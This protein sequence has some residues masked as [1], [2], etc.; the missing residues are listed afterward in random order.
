MNKKWIISI[1]SFIVVLLFSL[2]IYRST[3]KEIKIL[4]YEDIKEELNND[5][6]S[7]VYFGK[8]N[9]NISTLLN[10]F[11]KNNEFEIYYSSAN[12]D[13]LNELLK[14]NNLKTDNLEVFVLFMEGIPYKVL[15]NDLD[16]NEYTEQIS[17]YFYGT[18]PEDE[19]VYKTPNNAEQL[20]KKINS[21]NYTVMI[22]GQESCHYCDLYKNVFNE[23]ADL[24]KLDIYYI[25]VDTFSADEYKKIQD[26]NYKIPARCTKN[27]EDTTLSGIIPKPITIITK[28]GK[29]V[30]CI[31]GYVG[32]N[33]LVN[34]LMEYNIVKE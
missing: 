19:I 18:I 21:K 1:F 8:E 29:F 32:K 13:E 22:I 6:Y 9:D 31:K 16:Y 3:Y 33:I 34:K 5:V 30:D 28:K 15:A 2:I 12:I 14:T 26:L 17:K 24:Y 10:D 25:D 27:G 20:L 11:T 7:I 4:S 23:V